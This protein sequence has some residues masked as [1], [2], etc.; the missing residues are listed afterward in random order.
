[1]LVDQV[2]T[3]GGDAKARDLGPVGVRCSG[4]HTIGEQTE[5]ASDGRALEG[6]VEVSPPKT[7]SAGG[8]QEEP[9]VGERGGTLL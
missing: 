9:Q 2:P 5:L 1:V 7:P 3:A 4:V 6:L 8:E